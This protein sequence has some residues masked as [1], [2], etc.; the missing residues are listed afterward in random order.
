MKIL[1]NN[2]NDNNENENENKNKRIH[3]VTNKESY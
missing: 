1:N 2:S 3:K